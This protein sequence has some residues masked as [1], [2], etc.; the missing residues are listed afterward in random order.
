MLIRTADVKFICRLH[1]NAYATSILLP[2]SK[3]KTKNDVLLSL[4]MLDLSLY[5]LLGFSSYP[6]YCEK[7]HG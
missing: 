6:C 7:G 5:G 1:L 3:T 4:I 2:S